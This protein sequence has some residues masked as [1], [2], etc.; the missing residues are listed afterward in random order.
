[1]ESYVKDIDPLFQLLNSS[2]V[3]NRVKSQIQSAIVEISKK[4]SDKYRVISDLQLENA[5][6]K[7]SISISEANNASLIIS[8][9]RLKKKIRNT[10]LSDN[11]R[12]NS[13][14]EK[15]EILKSIAKFQENILTAQSKYTQSLNILDL[16]IEKLKAQ[17]NIASSIIDIQLTKMNK[18]KMELKKAKS[19]QIC[20]YR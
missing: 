17:V 11:S 7:K 3:S 16:Q 8:N 2:D 12:Q 20:V 18:Y 13:S 1:M 15:K 19:S 5:E 4:F 14:L 10:V 9:S 6:L